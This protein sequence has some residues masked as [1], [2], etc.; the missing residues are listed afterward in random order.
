[1]K[2]DKQEIVQAIQEWMEKRNLKGELLEIQGFMVG[3][4]W[5]KL[6]GISIEFTADAI[7]VSEGPYR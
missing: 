4:G 1:M 3:S 5:F 6:G 2:L 7:S